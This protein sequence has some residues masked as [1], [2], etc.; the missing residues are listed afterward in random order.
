MHLTPCLDRKTTGFQR[1][2]GFLNSEEG[3]WLPD[4]KAE[5]YLGI[6]HFGE[7]FEAEPVPIHTPMGVALA[8]TFLT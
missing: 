5:C 8:I 3:G 2:L 4:Q 6:R 1:G 7:V